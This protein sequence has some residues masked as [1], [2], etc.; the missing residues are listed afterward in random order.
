MSFWLLLETNFGRFFWVFPR[1]L[2][3]LTSFFFNIP[4]TAAATT[5][6][7]YYYCHSVLNR[8]FLNGLNF[9]ELIFLFIFFFNFL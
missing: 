1:L 5:Y 6:Y 7:Y 9:A 3:L 8:V 2:L 4:T